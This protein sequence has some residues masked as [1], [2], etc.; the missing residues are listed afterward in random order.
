MMPKKTKANHKYKIQK[1]NS[2][3]WRLF[4]NLKIDRKSNTFH[5]NINTFDTD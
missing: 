4:I 5:T 2:T 1:G 3:L